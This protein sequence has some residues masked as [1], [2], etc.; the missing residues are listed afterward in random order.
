MEELD[1]KELFMI[2]W[3]KKLEIILITLATKTNPIIKE[4]IPII[5]YKSKNMP[6]ISLSFNLLG[7]A[8]DL[9]T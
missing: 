4:I 1:L 7:L 2:F 6:F 8:L 5:M 9:E 3:N